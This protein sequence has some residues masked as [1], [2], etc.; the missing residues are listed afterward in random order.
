MYKFIFTL[1]CILSQY[2]ISAQNI[3]HLCVNDTL[4]NFA[5]P[6]TNG[7][8]YNWHLSSNIA[9][10][11]SGN[12]TEHILLDLNNTGEFWLHVEEIDINL[13]IGRDSIRIYVH[14]IPDPYIYAIGDPAF[15]DGDYVTLISD[16][17]YSSIVWNNGINEREIDVYNDGVYYITAEDS[18]GCI[19]NSN[20]I[21]VNVHPNPQANFI[22]DGECFGSFTSFIDSS[23]ISSGSI[24]EWKWNFGDQ[25]YDNGS[26]VNHLYNSIGI[27]NVELNI[28][29]EFGCVDSITKSIQIFHIP[30]AEFT[31]QPTQVSIL[32][33]SINFINNSINSS[34]ILW[35]FGDS[36]YSYEESP[37]HNYLNPGTYDV[38]LVVEDT[39]SCIDSVSYNV[40]VFYDFIL[41]VPESF[42]PNQDG[43]NEVFGPRGLRFQNFISYEFTIYNRWGEV[44][45]KTNDINAYWDGRP[46]NRN[47]MNFDVNDL[48]EEGVYTWSIIIQDEIGALRK[49]YGKVFLIR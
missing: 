46:M 44:V 30:K 11:N 2:V 34:P 26:I 38:T 3:V 12:G 1:L 13:C 20:L 40:S 21:H 27:Y 5:V 39:N 17:L 31:F 6:L 4:Q 29:S 23:I 37:T 7:S 43:I 32:N 28:E 49:K 41:Y 47:Y 48:V 8:T 14:D 36:T 9:T 18:N 33:P 22:I 24:L 35:D 16:S 10:I 19:A 25:N 42:T 45:F 15:C